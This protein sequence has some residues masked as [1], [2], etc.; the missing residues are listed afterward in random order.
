MIKKYG[1]RDGIIYIQIAPN[2]KKYVGQ[3]INPYTRF[4]RYKS[5]EG[6][7]QHH[8]N[9]LRKYGYDTLV[10]QTFKVP[11]FLLDDV[12]KSLIKYYQT[13]NPAKGYNKKEGGSAGRP[14][15]ETIDKI[16]NSTTGEKNHFFGKT[17]TEDAKKKIGIAHLGNTYRV[18]IK[19]TEEANKKNRDAHLGKTHTEEARRKNRDAQLGEKNHFFGK[20]HTEGSKIKMRDA[21]LG[22]TSTKETRG[23]MRDA[24]LGDKNHFFGKT[25]TKE[26]KRR[27]GDRNIG[28]KFRV[29]KTHTENTI[30]KMSKKVCVYGS[31]YNSAQKASNAIRFL[32]G[33]KSN[34][35]KKWVISP[36]YPDIFYVS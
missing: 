21:Q 8:T 33:F 17:H 32:Y 30:D 19:H 36:K 3:T 24:H 35:I 16:R 28:N 11:E 10:I 4:K 18:G 34:F 31:I 2:G 22:K 23:K 1:I 5:Y 12:E 7:N 29:G 13:T 20:T 6:N 9:A 27:I 14:T 26:T 15:E 25:H